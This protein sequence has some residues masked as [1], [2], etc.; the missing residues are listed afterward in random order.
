VSTKRSRNQ[1]LVRKSGRRALDVLNQPWLKYLLPSHKKGGNS[2]YKG[3]PIYLADVRVWDDFWTRDDLAFWESDHRLNGLITRYMTEYEDKRCPYD[4]EELPLRIVNEMQLERVSEVLR[5]Q[6]NFI[7]R[8]C[9]I[10][11]QQTK[12]P[13]V[14]RIGDGEDAGWI[15]PEAEEGAKGKKPDYSGYLHDPKEQSNNEYCCENIP[16]RIP[17]DAK[18][19]NKIRHAMLPPNGSEYKPGKKNAQAHKV[20][21]QVHG[22]MDQHEARY[23][24]IL[25]ERELICL[26]R[27]DTGWGQLEIA[28]PISHT[29]IPCAETGTFNSK[30]AL[31]YLHWVVAH[32][33]SS[34]GWR[35]RSFGREP[36]VTA[37][38]EPDR[39]MELRTN[40]AASVR[41]LHKKTELMNRFKEETS[42]LSGR[43]MEDLSEKSLGWLSNL[44]REF[45]LA[46][47][48]T[49]SC[50]RTI[51]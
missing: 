49:S 1:R 48:E 22:Y 3:R 33:D 50:H 47:E 23:G 31:F 2:D 35:L 11:L 30:Y 9:A 39:E 44:W 5:K 8:L 26:R 34:M 15:S 46:L 13:V 16:N 20:L 7:L 38:P 29:T 10:E 6:I 17:G 4:L 18:L 37:S 32:D 40:N 19:Y 45:R 12:T 25:T 21:S 36:D 43:R 24:Y 28:A 42:T 51:M 27:K 14:T 41:S